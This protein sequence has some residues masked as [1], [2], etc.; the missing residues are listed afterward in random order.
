M[1][2]SM[3]TLLLAAAALQLTGLDA[4]NP[5][6]LRLTPWTPFTGPVVDLA[7]A[8]D[9]RL[10][11][12]VQAGY[13]FIITDSMQVA[14]RPFLDITGQVDYSGEKGL[15]GL[16]FAPDY[17]T[18]G[19]LYTHYVAPVGQGMTVISRW[20]VSTDPDSVDMASEDTLFTYDQPYPNHKG[21]DLDFGPDGMLYIPLGDGGSGGDPQGHAQDLSDPLGD[22]LRIDVSDPDTTYTVPADNPYVSA[23][24][25]T[26]KEIWASGLRNP[27]R[28]GF[29]LLTGDM[30]IGDVGQS[31]WEEWDL[32]PAGTGGANFG[33]RCYEGHAPYN[34][35]GCQPQ[36]FYRAPAVVHLNQAQPGGT[37][38]AAI[39]GRVY[40]G[41]QWPHLYG[42]YFYT[43]VC[44]PEFRNLRPDG[45][46]GFIDELSVEPGFAGFTCI[47]EDHT[48]ELFAANL[49]DGKVYKLS[50]RCPMDPPVITQAGNELH[51]PSIGSIQ[52]Y[53]EG[54]P[55]LGATDTVFAPGSSGAVHVMVDHGDQC[56]LS[57]DTLAFVYTGIV[58]LALPLLQAFPD[59]AN[60]VLYI[61]RWDA[62]SI[63]F[64]VLDR[65][66]RTVLEGPVNSTREGLRTADLPTGVYLLTAFDGKGSV[67]E[68]RRFTVVH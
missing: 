32:L 56:V 62:R 47:A 41:S 3:R 24:P 2:T 26:L 11:A 53:F 20:T 21:G 29:D 34:T 55:F 39:G 59:P 66:G 51:T 30:W 9:D 58:P 37:Y 54:L 14:S 1:F 31:A 25:D 22:I 5:A 52:W 18:T 57:S 63:T 28:F 33:W 17:A 49:G 60:D 27:F 46:G 43:D 16:A 35:A 44:A 68:R 38:C 23:G 4:Q 64:R 6:R 12:V 7:H 40:R 15:L 65:S 61:T 48:G 45:G 50:D 10:F 19:H 67:S 8:G 13:I 36:S 42:R